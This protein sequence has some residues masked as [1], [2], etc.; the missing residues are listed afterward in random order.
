M[1]KP[2][3]NTSIKEILS[4]IPLEM[5]TG[6]TL[7]SLF[8]CLLETVFD[9]SENSAVLLKLAD[10]GYLGGL[11]NRL[12]Y[13][14]T[15]VFAFSESADDALFSPVLLD[16]KLLQGEEFLII[17]ADRFT[18]CLYWEGTINDITELHQGFCSLN[19]HEVNLVVNQLKKVTSD[20]TLSNVI[21]NIKP[22]RRD[23]ER[24]TSILRKT[25]SV[26]DVQQRDLICLDSELEELRN[27]AAQQSIDD[28]TKAMSSFA[29]EI[30]NPLSSISMYA[31]IIAKNLDGL[32]DEKAEICH[33]AADV[34]NTATDRLNGFLTEILNYSKPLSMNIQQVDGKEV[35]D[36]IVN[37]MN[38][39]AQENGHSVICDVQEKFLVN[40]D[41]AK[42]SQVLLN[43][44]K[45]GLE[46]EGNVLVSAEASDDKVT[47]MI[48]DNGKGITSE[49]QQKLFQPFFTTK[50]DGSGIGLAYSQ[51]TIKAMGGFIELMSSDSGG[52]TFGIVLPLGNK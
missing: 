1:K 31:K 47:I 2:A 9:N 15:R 35:V 28:L 39:I 8:R 7:I 5:Y 13:S 10:Q 26:F 18:A 17:I 52:T 30:R 46:S 29:H 33:N 43:L 41:K 6:Q 11:L 42:L 34:I 40:A 37:L 27:R 25:A 45:N 48:T 38:P 16:K 22:D 20:K 4:E 44:V 21:D 36:E 32:S 51:K 12:K 3:K 50:K 14:K 23:N 19:P 24:F 49:N